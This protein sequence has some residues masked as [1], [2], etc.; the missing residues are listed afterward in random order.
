[1]EIAMSDSPSSKSSISYK[2]AEISDLPEDLEAMRDREVELL[3]EVWAR[4]KEGIGDDKR[5]KDFNAELAR[6]WA[7]ET[8]IVEGVYTLDRWIT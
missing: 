7:I 4:E 6:E 3:C 8:G 5:V 2:W 1:M